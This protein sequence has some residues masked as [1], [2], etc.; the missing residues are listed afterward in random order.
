MPFISDTQITRL[1]SAMASAQ[2]KMAS[3]RAKA[4]EKAGEIKDM[5]EIVGAAALIGF[6]RGY[7]EKEG[8]NKREFVVPGTSI[9]IE[10]VAGLALSGAALMD[11]FGKYDQDVANVGYGILAHYVGQVGR[12]WGKSG[13]FSLV[14]GANVGDDFSRA[15]SDM[16]I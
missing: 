2:T 8:P 4:E 15:L 7:M 11:L 13:S 9:D 12:N 3:A 16:V 1:Q 14:A 10:L 5:A 6:A